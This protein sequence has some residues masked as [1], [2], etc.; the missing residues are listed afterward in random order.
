MT[1]FLTLVIVPKEE[2]NLKTAVTELL[3]PYD[4]NIRVAPYKEYLTKREIGRMAKC[5]GKEKN[6]DTKV[7]KKNGK[8]NIKH[9]I[10]KH[11]EDWSGYEGGMDKKGAYHWN[12]YNP[13]SK[14]DW[15]EIGGRWSNL[16]KRICG[17]PGY[18]E[19]QDKANYKKCSYCDGTGTRQGCE[20]C[21]KSRPKNYLYPVIGKGCNACHGTGMSLN[22]DMIKRFPDHCLVEQLTKDEIGNDIITP[23]GVWHTMGRHGWWA[24]F[25]E[26]MSES[27]WV[28]EI[29]AI[30]TK[31]KGYTAVIVDCH[32]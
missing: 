15:Y 10:E 5:Y 26:E 30:L 25:K 9:L 1:H 29:K 17:E 20:W 22:F 31:Y 2:S 4:E 6:P 14:W 19:L 27:K 32:I 24:M 8:I 12:R 3:E 11:M 16:L 13:S 7:F 28:G 18:D 21:V 23:D